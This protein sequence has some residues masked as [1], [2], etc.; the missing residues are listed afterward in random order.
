[1]CVIE[2]HTKKA[3][4]ADR[5]CSVHLATIN[6]WYNSPSI[7]DDKM[8]TRPNSPF[9]FPCTNQTLL[10]IPCLLVQKNLK[11]KFQHVQK[12][13]N[14]KYNNDEIVILQALLKIATLF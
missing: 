4:N 13:I 1:M 6:C 8:A 2:V 14:N 7:C 10:H 12:N 9:K 11:C 5:N 3:T